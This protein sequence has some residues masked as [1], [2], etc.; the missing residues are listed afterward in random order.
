MHICHDFSIIEDSSFT[1]K[2]DDRSFNYGDGI[3]ETMVSF[4]GQI[5]WLED[6][7]D[8]LIS[9]CSTLQLQLPQGLNPYSIN[10]LTNE[11]IL[12]N[13]LTGHIRIKLKVWRKDGGLYTPSTNETHF[14]ILVSETTLNFQTIE[15]AGIAKNVQL[16][17]HAFS[18]LKTSNSL[19]Y[20]LAAL[21]R[22]ERQLNEIILTDNEGNL[23]ECVS[24]N[25]FWIKGNVFYTPDLS[26]GCLEGIGRKN[27]ISYLKRKKIEIIEGNYKYPSLSDAD[28]IFTINVLGIRYLNKIG[29]QLF[30]KSNDVVLDFITEHYLN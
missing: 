5:R 11:L 6:H 12:K 23:A 4:N 7:W 28:T 19:P 16:Y 9:G 30:N 8:R 24:S 1:V 14:L 17:N 26:T 18:S 15:N 27:L 22:K 3:F 13:D 21:E 2:L 29:I 10:L 20:I 25:L